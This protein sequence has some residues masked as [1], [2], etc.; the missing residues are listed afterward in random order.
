MVGVS[1]VES[2]KCDLLMSARLRLSTH[3]FIKVGADGASDSQEKDAKK[4][5]SI[6][7]LVGEAVGRHDR[8]TE[9]SCFYFI[10]FF[11]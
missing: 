2:V 8:V 1:L 3:K 9:V 5:K 7:I 6:T 10:I 11:F 4:K